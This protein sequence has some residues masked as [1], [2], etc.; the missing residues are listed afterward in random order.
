MTRRHRA[1]IDVRDDAERMFVPHDEVP[2]ARIGD[3]IELV[4]TNPPG[5]H[6]ATVIEL[7]DDRARGRFVIATIDRNAEVRGAEGS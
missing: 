2:G 1:E 4:S 7:V 5:R 3:E 6:I